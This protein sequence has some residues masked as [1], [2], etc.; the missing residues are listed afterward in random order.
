MNPRPKRWQRVPYT[1]EH[2]PTISLPISFLLINLRTKHF[3][4]WLMLRILNHKLIYIS[5]I[6]FYIVDFFKNTI[7]NNVLSVG[8]KYLLAFCKMVLNAKLIKST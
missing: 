5:I 8:K 6:L 1:V 4:V 3:S 7:N 2:V